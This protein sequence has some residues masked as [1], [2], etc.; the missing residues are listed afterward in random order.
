VNAGLL[1]VLHDR[2]D[3]GSLAV[4]DA[5]DIYFDRVWGPGIAFAHDPGSFHSKTKKIV[6]PGDIKGMKIIWYFHEDDEDMEE[7]GE[8]FSELV[9]ILRSGAAR[10][11]P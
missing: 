11:R 4:G 8:E 1:D 6:V 10:G 5:I 7:A 3:H 2:A 9:E